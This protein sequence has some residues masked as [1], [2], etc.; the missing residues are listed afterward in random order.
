MA[1]SQDGPSCPK[2]VQ[3]DDQSSFSGGAPST[4][5]G[6]SQPSGH[7]ISK[8]KKAARPK[9]KTARA[10][11]VAQFGE[12]DVVA[13]QGQMENPELN[14]T[15]VIVN[16]HHPKSGLYSVQIGNTTRKM[17]PEHLVLRY[18]AGTFCSSDPSG[19]DS[20]G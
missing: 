4:N 18:P 17:K 9:R 16:C 5:P 15:L 14:G 3:Q 8:A 1:K 19:S 20:G 11:L 6:S 2:F 10:S 13:I 12:D 7:A